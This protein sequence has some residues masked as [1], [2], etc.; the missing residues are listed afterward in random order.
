MAG[1][2][3]FHPLVRCADADRMIAERAGLPVMRGR[4]FS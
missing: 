4:R 2:T 3:S 1:N